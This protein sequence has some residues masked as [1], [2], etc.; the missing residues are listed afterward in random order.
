VEAAVTGSSAGLS[1]DEALRTL[2][3]G[4]DVGKV[5]R[6]E[7]TVEATGVGITT[8]AEY[9]RRHYTWDNLASQSQAQRGYQ[10]PKGGRPPWLE[11]D[12]FTHWTV[13]LRVV[14]Q[15]L[16]AKGVRN[17]LI[18]AMVATADAPDEW[19]VAVTVGDQRVLTADDVQFH[20]LRLRAGYTEHQ[21]GSDRP[22]W[23]IWRR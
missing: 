22:W 13:L 2:A 3:H 15:M 7:L 16:E 5:R 23:A 14:G 19:A 12:A 1:L 6:A 11:A 20:L 8:N 10:R 17:C 9:G 4:L 21:A 18:D